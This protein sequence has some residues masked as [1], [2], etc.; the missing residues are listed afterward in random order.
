LCDL[1]SLSILL[2]LA[3]LCG[4][5]FAGEPDPA[6]G[7]PPDQAHYVCQ[8]IDHTTRIRLSLEGPAGKQHARLA[9][10]NDTAFTMGPLYESAGM[11]AFSELVP[12]ADDERIV[13]RRLFRFDP[14]TASLILVDYEPSF[15]MISAECVLDEPA[16]FVH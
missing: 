12:G 4:P 1:E 3:C 11:L 10:A 15:R 9:V 14:R 5:A 2:V 13:S 6:S 16:E 8:D 7:G